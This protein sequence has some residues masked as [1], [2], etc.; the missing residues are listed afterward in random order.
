MKKLALLF[1]FTL[2]SCGIF[3]LGGTTET[4][5]PKDV[6]AARVFLRS[7]GDAALRTW[8]T[9][10]LRTYQPEL[11]AIFDANQNG[12]LELPEIEGLIDVSNPDSVT[13]L[14]V[15]AITLFQHRPK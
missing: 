3:N 5:E 11:F 12:V 2:A 13:S 14:M 10:A 15:V 9:E 4:G 1:L 7:L 6:D 8:G